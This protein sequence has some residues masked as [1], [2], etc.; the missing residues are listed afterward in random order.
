[1]ALE[2]EALATWHHASLFA[3]PRAS[4]SVFTQSGFTL[5]KVPVTYL[6][7]FSYLVLL[8]LFCFR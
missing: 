6:L 4:P 3:E 5:A 7:M 1:M 2:E 8:M